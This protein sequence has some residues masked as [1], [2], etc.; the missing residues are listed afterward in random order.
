MISSNSGI[1]FIS[2]ARA[3]GVDPESIMKEPEFAEYMRGYLSENTA[4]VTFTKKDGSSRVMRC[5]RDSSIIPLAKLPKEDPAK[6]AKT[7]TGDAVQAFDLD[8]GEW[9]AFNT[10]NITR[11][12]WAQ[13]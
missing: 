11:I 9:R 4:T 7:P 13:L 8:L 12:E 6:P 10:G 1:D 5:T 2:L 3:S